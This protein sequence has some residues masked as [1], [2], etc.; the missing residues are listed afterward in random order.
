MLW[1]IF[2]STHERRDAPGVKV[3]K[4]EPGAQWTR[5]LAGTT[6]VLPAFRRGTFKVTALDG[7]PLH[8]VDRVVDSGCG[9]GRRRILHAHPC[10]RFARCRS[11]RCRDRR[12]Y[13]WLPAGASPRLCDRG[14]G[15]AIGGA[16]DRKTADDP[17]SFGSGGQLRADRE[18]GGGSRGGYR[19]A[20]TD[21]AL[22]GGVVGACAR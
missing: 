15:G 17:Y 9:F 3:S 7:R 18:E 6:R 5:D 8:A 21:Q 4:P 1:V 14:C 11:T 16:A 2:L 22:G 10:V 19:Y 13:R 12:R 20:G